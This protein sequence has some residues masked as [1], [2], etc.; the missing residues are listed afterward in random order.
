MRWSQLPEGTSIT[1]GRDEAHAAL[2]SGRKS[3]FVAGV[4]VG[5][6]GL[7]MLQSNPDADATPKPDSKHTSTSIPSPRSPKD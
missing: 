7:G 4:V 3:A 2:H 6:I 5:V 1:L